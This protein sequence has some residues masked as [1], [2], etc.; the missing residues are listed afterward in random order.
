MFT[1]CGRAW[2]LCMVPVIV[3]TAVPALGQLVS[4]ST[5]FRQADGSVPTTGRHRMQVQRLLAD[6]SSPVRSKREGAERE[7]ANVMT[8]GDEPTLQNGLH[9]YSWRSAA[10]IIRLLAVMGDQRAIASILPFVHSPHW[11]LRAAAARALGL[12]GAATAEPSLAVALHHDRNKRVRLEAAFAL[13]NL[14]TGPAYKELASALTDPSA[15]VAMTAAVALAQATEPHAAAALSRLV[16]ADAGGT[17]RE[18]AY[19]AAYALG[20]QGDQSSEPVLLQA[21]HDRNAN[22]R[23]AAAGAL[24]HLH[25]RSAVESLVIALRDSSR[26]VRFTAAQALG[27]IGDRRALPALLKSLKDANEDVREQSARALGRLRDPKAIPAL[28]YAAYHDTDDAIPR[29]AAFALG[30]IGDPVART[31][32][33]RLEKS[34][35]PSVSSAARY[36]LTILR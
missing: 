13:G 21:L 32:L 29:A 25:D 14:H 36:A 24:G 12:L 17:H 35:D 33:L 4:L 22:M 27:V 23:A 8:R 2:L 7:L 30:S 5:T 3:M 6:L 18:A 34:K 11:Q 1:R 28:I 15:A 31:A 19:Y 26:M 10:Q 20:E 16:R 9:R